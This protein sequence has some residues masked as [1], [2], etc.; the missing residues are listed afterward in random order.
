MG[1]RH[2]VRYIIHNSVGTYDTLDKKIFFDEIFRTIL[3][4]VL[5]HL[6]PAFTFDDRVKA[7]SAQHSFY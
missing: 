5:K 4:G 7:Q 1:L 2:C 3:H 6:N